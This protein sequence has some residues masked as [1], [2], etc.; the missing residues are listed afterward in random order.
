MA[1]ILVHRNGRGDPN[2]PTDYQPLDVV[3]VKE[4]GLSWGSR[5]VG[6]A[7]SFFLIRLP[8]VPKADV[9]FLMDFDFTTQSVQSDTDPL[10]G[11]PV[12]ADVPTRTNRR[13]HKFNHNQ[14]PKT[15][16]D[17]VTVN[18]DGTVDLQGFEITLT[19]QDQSKFLGAIGV[20]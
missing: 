19:G 2:D 6:P 1:E 12:F 8:G 9:A 10:T 7:T 18:P 15:I 14:M 3:S 17:I 16:K 20:K 13:K 4:D 5:E 11:D